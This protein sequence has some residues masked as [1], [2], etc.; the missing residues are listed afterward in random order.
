MH[1]NSID[2]AFARIGETSTKPAE[3]PTNVEQLEASAADI[4]RA[5]AN[6]DTNVDLASGLSSA[7]PPKPGLDEIPVTIDGL[8]GPVT[9]GDLMRGLE[10]AAE[11][12]EAVQSSLAET[13]SNEALGNFLGEL[14]EVQE[15]GELI[16][17]VTG[18][19]AHYIQGHVSREEFN[20]SVEEAAR[21]WHFGDEVAD[22]DLDADD[23]ALIRETASA[24]QHE[25]GRILKAQ[26][27][28][29]LEA[30]AEEQAPEL[31]EQ[32]VQETAEA[33][34]SWQ[35]EAGLT[36]DVARQ[37]LTEIEAAILEDTGKSLAD[38]FAADPAAAADLLRAE[39][40]GIEATEDEFSAH[41][42]RQGILDAPSTSISDGLTQMTPF[43]E[44]RLQ[45]R[46]ELSPDQQRISARTIQ[47]ARPRETVEQIKSG[48]L[49]TD[50]SSVV[51]GYTDGSGA[52]TSAYVLSGLEAREKLER[53]QQ[54]ARDRGLLR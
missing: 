48:L 20:E 34:K 10:D 4:K 24:L 43:G 23:L 40:A 47:T 5:L 21:V 1:P 29:R 2:D 12:L 9:A 28:A 38:H 8:D 45:P 41:E 44:M 52:K 26:D 3:R 51:D 16:E 30:L 18:L 46:P 27:D 25:A 19:A 17:A 49:E 31:V 32:R 15:G 6:P 42:I 7:A 36:G 35:L 33:V 14:D 50:T 37:K 39:H 53:E 22:S 13:Q 54:R 11:Q